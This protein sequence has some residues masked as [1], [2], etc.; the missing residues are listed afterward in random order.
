MSTQ[1]SFKQLHHYLTQLSN[2]RWFPKGHLGNQE[3]QRIIFSEWTEDG[4]S[5]PIKNPIRWL[6]IKTGKKS[7]R[8]QFISVNI[9]NEVPILNTGIRIHFYFTRIKGTDTA[10]IYGDTLYLT[11]YTQRKGIIREERRKVKLLT[12]NNYL[13]RVAHSLPTI[14]TIF[15]QSQKKK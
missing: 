11:P 8:D 12:R 2:F 6:E 3:Y 15:Q 4:E 1:L 10:R 7:V 14:Q 5:K 9:Y 13:Y